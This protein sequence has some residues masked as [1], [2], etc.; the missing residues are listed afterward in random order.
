M[1]RK[2]SHFKAGREHEQTQ[3][4]KKT[5]RLREKKVSVKNWETKIKKRKKKEFEKTTKHG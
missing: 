1:G 5:T 2:T 3:N 4:T